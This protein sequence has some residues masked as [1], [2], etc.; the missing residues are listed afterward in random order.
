MSRTRSSSTSPASSTTRRRPAAVR[1]ASTSSVFIRPSRS[2]CSTTTTLTSGSASSRRALVRAPFIPDPT[3]VSTRTTRRPACAAHADKR[4]T[5]RSRSDFWS[6]DDTRAY[7]PTAANDSG[8]AAAAS[9]LTRMV[10]GPT[11]VAGTGR[12][13]SRNQRYAVCGCTPCAFAHSVRFIP[14]TLAP[15][16]VHP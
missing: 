13:P 3:S 14:A 16:Y 10:R 2:R 5:W 15:T 1:A 9:T 11:R 7:K 6:C 4:A 12:V 8:T